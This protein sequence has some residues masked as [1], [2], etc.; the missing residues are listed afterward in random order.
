[1]LVSFVCCLSSAVSNLWRRIRTSKIKFHHDLN[2]SSSTFMDS[3]WFG[4]MKPSDS[5][6]LVLKQWQWERSASDTVH[7]CAFDVV[8]GLKSPNTT[9]QRAFHTFNFYRDIY[10]YISPSL[11]WGNSAWWPLYSLVCKM[12]S[13]CQLS[14]S[15]W[16]RQ[17]YQLA[18]TLEIGQASTH[19]FH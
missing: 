9:K 1:M 12:A 5:Q 14:E 8:H 11:C 17:E 4:Y 2:C 15:N 7:T 19:H 3:G 18:S 10:I 13:S 6:C 16:T